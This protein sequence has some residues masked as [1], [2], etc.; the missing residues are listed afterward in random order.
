M[1]AADI[2]CCGF[3]PVYVGFAELWHAVEHLRQV[4]QTHERQRPEFNRQQAM[5]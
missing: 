5:T 4:L 2:M 3:T 1:D